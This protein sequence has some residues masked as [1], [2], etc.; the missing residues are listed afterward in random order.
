MDRP[1]SLALSGTTG[2]PQSQPAARI[3]TISQPNPAPNA[4]I[5]PRAPAGGGIAVAVVDSGLDIT[6][7]DIAAN[8]FTNP[9]EI[10]GNGVDD[11]G[12]GHVDDVHGYDVLSD[13]GT[14][15]DPNGHG[16]H[17]AGTIAAVGNN[18]IG[19]VGVAPGVRIMPVRGISALGTSTSP[20]LAQAM[21]YAIENGADVMNNSWG[22]R[23]ACPSNP[24]IEDMVRMG[25]ALGV[26]TVF[27]A[28]NED[29]NV[30]EIS[31]QNMTDPMYKPIVVAAHDE[32]RKPARFPNGGTNFGPTV[33]VM[34]AGGGTFTIT[35]PLRVFN[36]L[37]LRSQQ[38]PPN[39]SSGSCSESLRVPLN[40]G[41]YSR[42]A[43]TSMAAPHVSGLAALIASCNPALLSPDVRHIAEASAR[44][45]LGDDLFGN[46][47]ISSYGAL[48]LVGSPTVAITGPSRF[49]TF[50]AGSTVE[51]KATMSGPEVHSWRVYVAN[52]APAERLDYTLLASGNGPVS[53]TIAQWTPTSGGEKSVKIRVRT[54]L[55]ADRPVSSTYLCGDP[56]PP[57]RVESRYLE[58]VQ[59]FSVEGQINPEH[60][61]QRVTTSSFDHYE[62]PSISG[63]R[64]V[65]EE[66]PNLG[67]TGRI[68]ARVLDSGQPSEVIGAIGSRQPRLD[69]ASPGR[70]VW[71][72]PRTGSDEVWMYEFLGGVS[73]QLTATGR[74]KSRPRIS[75][76]WVAFLEKQADGKFQVALH[77]RNAATTTVLTAGATVLTM[78][79][80]GDWL[81]WR[82]D[83]QDT[84]LTA[85]RLS[86]GETTT[87]PTGYETTCMDVS[88]NWVVSL[89]QDGDLIFVPYGRIMARNLVTQQNVEVDGGIFQPEDGVFGCPSISGTL[90]GYTRLLGM[91]T[92]LHLNDFIVVG[93]PTRVT[94]DESTLARNVD[95]SGDRLVWEDSRGD[96]ADQ[97][98]TYVR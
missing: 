79:M 93:G 1:G 96:I 61:I 81:L 24:P 27:A 22:C 56:R 44:K 98:W 40:T 2:S 18:G 62:A 70:M 89:T 66:H 76:N 72:D 15:V 3:S 57:S 35:E 60:Q 29:R 71:I 8:V 28:G 26:V 88:G 58:E 43:G 7:P 16:T 53:G 59:F 5:I 31:P 17:V 86:T 36:V 92:H 83:G 50:S 78:A 38:C 39:A 54:R 48:A 51:I 49:Q 87:V 41:I 91:T 69:D 68:F 4:S 12:N 94:Y 46:G 13:S 73:S 85:R 64:V 20:I 37:S 52:R 11:D 23:S 74:V 42:N 6:H 30:Y 34:A 14:I 75:G 10:A 84:S 82:A 90:V 45:R 67:V 32:R 25:G 47:P 63:D 33:D 77:D 55:P 95:V 97:I 21:Q 9:F 65:A 80:S 19:V